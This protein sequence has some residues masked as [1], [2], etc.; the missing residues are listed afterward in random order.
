LKK[1]RKKTNDKYF[2]LIKKHFERTKP[3]DVIQMSTLFLHLQRKEENQS[4][5]IFLK[6]NQMKEPC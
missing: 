4:L 3:A 2:L 6:K 1:I 5:E